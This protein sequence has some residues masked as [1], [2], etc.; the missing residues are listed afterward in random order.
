MFPDAVLVRSISL[1]GVR[2]ALRGAVDSDVKPIEGL[3]YGYL[4]LMASSRG[5]TV[6]AGWAKPREVCR[7]TWNDVV[8]VV[9]ATFN[10]HHR[11]LHGLEIRLLQNHTSTSVPFVILGTGFKGLVPPGLEA[12]AGTGISMVK[13]RR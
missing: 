13:L 6:W 10:V 9:P 8:D 4:T 12:I 11:G 7:W 5:V 1:S 2:R 3:G